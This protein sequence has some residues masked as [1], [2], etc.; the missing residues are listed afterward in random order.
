MKASMLVFC[1]AL[2]FLSTFSDAAEIHATGILLDVSKSV[3]PEEF[4]R[5]KGIVQQIADQHQ[6]SSAV[7][8]LYIFGT[9]LDRIDRSQLASVQ[10]TQ[11]YTMFYDALYDVMQDLKQVTADQRAIIILSDGKDT[12]SVT[13]PE[14]IAS[15]A[16]EQN[17]SIH[18]VGIGDANRKLLERIA[19]LTGGAYFSASDPELVSRIKTATILKNNHAKFQVPETK[20]VTKNN[21]RP[22][23][24]PIATP[25]IPGNQKTLP[26]YK[27]VIGALGIILFVGY[28]LISRRRQRRNCPVC[29]KPLESFDLICSD[30]PGQ[31]LMQPIPSLP[32]PQEQISDEPRSY[33]EP[34]KVFQHP[35]PVP[36]SGFIELKQDTEEMLSKTYF[37]DETPA[38]VVTRGKSVGERYRLNKKSPVS[39]GRSRL[40]E[41]RPEDGSVCAQH[42]RIIA[43]NGEYVLYDLGSTNGTLV[44][45]I[46]VNMAVLE[47]GDTIRVGATTFLFTLLEN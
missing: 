2:I 40:N 20:A 41:I 5:I 17:I 43:E 21:E 12:K 31:T 38:L 10:A 28:A 4:E 36:P 24:V 23:S 39:I 8:S 13:T 47:E 27:W 22:S 26:S 11:S 14:D 32:S 7:L 34:S 6:S 42:C 18:C 3:S 35:I 15:F 25:V 19:K 33:E 45:N 16:R 29:G 30:C 44:N 46:S 37:L 9:K 1:I